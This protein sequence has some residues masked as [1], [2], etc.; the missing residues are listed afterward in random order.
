MKKA[1]LK[2]IF[3][4]L[5]FLVSAC[6]PAGQASSLIAIKIQ[7]G[8]THQAVYGGFYA[9]DQNSDYT[10]EGLAISFIEGGASAD[11]ISSLLDNTAQF[12]IMGASSIISARA[13]GKPIRALATI[14]RR[15]P[16]VFFSLA[17]SGIVRLQ[18]FVDKK[19]LVSPILQSRLYGMLT[20][21]DINRNEITLVS[22]GN[23]VDLYTG[24]IDVASGL[25]TSSVLMAKQ[26]GYSV[27]IINP[28]DYGVHFYSST[29]YA[30]DDYIASNPE[31]VA[32]FLRATFKGWSY[33]VAD[34]QAVGMMVAHYDPKA[35]V[36]F[37]AA[38]MAASVP[39]I[40]TGEDHIGWMNP[41]VWAGMLKTM[42]EEGQAITVLDITEVYT[43]KF[44]QQIYGENKP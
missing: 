7:L 19:V 39:Y 5:S 40:N 33:A 20:K 4:I 34:P 27:N 12:G 38:S 43:L 42:H 36:A 30:T 2:K 14:L 26:S 1:V 35:D 23:F 31:I 24:K 28:D 41:D 6:A 17:S 8:A 22:T 37:E 29:I 15:D 21:A 10:H 44:L 13:A 25:I 32:K 16:V 18:D 3:T 11:P 9:A